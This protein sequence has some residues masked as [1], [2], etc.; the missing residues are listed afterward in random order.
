LQRTAFNAE[1]DSIKSDTPGL[2]KLI[3][4]S[5]DQFGIYTVIIKNVKNIY[6]DFFAPKKKLSP[7]ADAGNKL[8]HRKEIDI[9]CVL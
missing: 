1:L 3:G 4:S 7:Y 2:Y 8:R 5:W 9:L 6:I